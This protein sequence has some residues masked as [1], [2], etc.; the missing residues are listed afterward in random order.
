M[1]SEDLRT[2]QR[3]AQET[4]SVEDQARVL[5]ERLR[6]GL[7]TQQRLE[8]AAYVG[9]VAARLVVPPVDRL[10][11][12]ADDQLER[13][14]DADDWVLTAWC[15]GLSLWGEAICVRATVAAGRG[16]QS[17]WEA[18]VFDDGGAPDCASPAAGGRCGDCSACAVVLAADHALDSAQA[19]LDEPST[20]YRAQAMLP[21]LLAGRLIKFWHGPQLVLEQHTQWVVAIERASEVVDESAIRDA[22]HE[23][24]ADW[25]LG[26]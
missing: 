26:S 2:L 22:I 4:R 8:L 7:I 19:W 20:E 12:K 9:N 1:R 11:D 10:S 3:R 23:G 13:W 5:A 24:L 18:H 14:E 25:A 17:W 21:T 15:R 16:A 6:R